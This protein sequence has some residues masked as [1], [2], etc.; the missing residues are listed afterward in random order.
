ML[1]RERPSKAEPEPAARTFTP[2]AQSP[3]QAAMSRHRHRGFFIRNAY[4]R[5]EREYRLEL[6]RGGFIKALSSLLTVDERND[7]YL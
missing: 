4:Q 1:R 3:M 6:D 2:E 5:M 7:G